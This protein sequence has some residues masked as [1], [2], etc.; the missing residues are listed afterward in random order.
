MPDNIADI[1]LTFLYEIADGSDEFIVE[2]IGL[3]LQQSP[4]ILG[5]VSDAIN[6]G[7]WPTAASSAHSIKANLGFFGMQNSNAL[8]VEVESA[9]KAGGQD[10]AGIR[11]K[12]NEARAIINNALIKLSEIKAEREANL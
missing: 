9:C 4:E 11:A 2:S 5:Q 3:F 7:D 12:F 10:P 8:I 1:D 6:R